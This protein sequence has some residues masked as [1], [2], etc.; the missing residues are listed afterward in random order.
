MNAADSPETTGPADRRTERASQKRKSRRKA[1][2]DEARRV[3]AAKGYH[4]THVADIIEAC[5]IARGTFYLYF[6]SK[7]AIFRELLESLL[8]ELKAN[9]VGLDPDDVGLEFV[10]QR[11]EQLA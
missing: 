10:E 11:V 7:A 9:I 4:Q 1:V 6:D 5:G 2:L 3:F 8:D